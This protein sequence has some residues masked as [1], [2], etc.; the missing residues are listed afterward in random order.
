LLIS[1]VHENTYV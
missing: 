1:Q